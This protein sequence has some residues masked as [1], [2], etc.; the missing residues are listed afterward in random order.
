MIDAYAV[1]LNRWVPFQ[2]RDFVFR[3]MFEKPAI[4][5]EARTDE[6]VRNVQELV[7]LDSRYVKWIQ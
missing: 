3:K 2:Y 4:L 6:I 5:F 7:R 1:L